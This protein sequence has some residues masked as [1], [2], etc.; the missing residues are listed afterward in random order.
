MLV[1]NRLVLT[2]TM[3][4][5]AVLPATPRATPP[6]PAAAPRPA[7]DFDIGD[8]RALAL[9]SPRAA[10]AARE[11]RARRPDVTVRYDGRHGVRTIVS[12]EKG[13]SGPEA[14]PARDVARAYLQAI[15]PALL[16]LAADDVR[17]LRV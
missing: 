7:P 8:R 9:D 4:M 3:I 12:A 16:D 11:L 2:S 15:D 1:L 10:Q 14:R 5:T 13:L 6:T 17:R